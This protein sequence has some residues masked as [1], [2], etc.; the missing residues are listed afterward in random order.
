MLSSCTTAILAGVLHPTVPFVWIRCHSPQRSLRWWNTPNRL[1]DVGALQDVEVRQ[2][3][4]DPQ[5]N[6][7][8]FLELLPEFADYEMDPLQM[9]R[10]VP[11]TLTLDR[12]AEQAVNRT[13]IQSNCSGLEVSRGGSGPATGDLSAVVHRSV[14]DQPWSARAGMAGR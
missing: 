5:L 14:R 11:D 1:S 7:A 8:R 13:L 3:R 10:R 9:A 6:T 2:L 4:F 12:I